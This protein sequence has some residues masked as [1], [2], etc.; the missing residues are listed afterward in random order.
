MSNKTPLQPSLPEDELKQHQLKL[1]HED[2]VPIHKLVGDIN[3]R[4]EEEQAQKLATQFSLPY[5]NLM[6]Y[7]PEAGVVDILPKALAQE[8][9]IFAFKKDGQ[10]VYLALSDPEHP[11]TL[12]G[13]EQLQVQDEYN[14]IPVL[15]SDSSMRYLISIYDI[16]APKNVTGQEIKITAARQKAASNEIKNWQTAGDKIKNL[17]TSQL[18]ETIVSSATQAEASDI[19]IEPTEE[20]THLRFRIDGMLQDIA[21]LPKTQL[22]GLVS[23]IKLLSNLKLN[24]TDSAQDG[25]FNLKVGK[26]AYDIRVSILPTAYGESAVLRLL[27]QS[28][29]FISLD[30]LGLVGN[31]AQIVESIIREPNG[32]ILN[33]GPTG[34]GKT[35][36]LYAILNKINRPDKKIITIEDPIEYRLA[37]I[38]QSQVNPEEDYTF[39]TGLRSI[40]RQ[41]PDI[42]LVGEIRDEDTADIAVNASLT[43]HLVLSTL[44][45]NDAAGAIPRLADL[46]LTP[47]YFIEAILAIIAQRLVRRVCPNQCNEDYTPDAAE[48]DAI[49]QEL[50]KLPPTI[51]KPALPKTLKRVNPEKSADCQ[52]CNG[53]GYKGRIG[54]F[55][56]LQPNE[57]IIKAVLASSTIGEIKKLAIANGMVTLKQD[58]LLKVL[59]GITTL[60]EVDR[61]TREEE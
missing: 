19:H 6:N 18:F 35:T 51:D 53:T 38:T 21:D 25:R 57:A 36:T 41:D 12:K 34:S 1:Q 52:Y 8:S 56:I 61:V 46:G 7:Q 23:R 28:G 31:N 55:E 48:W 2:T 14:F 43:G 32:L 5:L 54:I 9:K 40:L 10:N 16:F 30:K 45:T 49:N 22:P 11:Q 33:T 44:H 39:A 4:R 26:V 58:G 42:V 17:P 37:G 47:K 50:D 27:P 3:R 60:E 20:N 15:V 13:L 59:E 29:K 24:I